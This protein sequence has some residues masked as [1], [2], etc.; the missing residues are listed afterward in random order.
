M[1]DKSADSVC[2]FCMSVYSY[3]LPVIR[4]PAGDGSGD[5]VAM[6]GEEVCVCAVDK[7]GFDEDG[8][9][10]G[11]AEDAEGGMGFYAAVFIVCV[12]GGEAFYQLVLDGAGKSAARAVEVVAV[13]FCAAA[14]A[15]VDVDAD[16]DIGG[17]VVGRVH[18]AGGAG[19]FAVEVMALQK[20]DF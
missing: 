4:H 12:K 17:P 8:G 10:G 11:V 7:A 15:G 2:T 9:H 5:V 3:I 19:G 20:F 18:D 6:A 13:G 14:A 1:N 16:E